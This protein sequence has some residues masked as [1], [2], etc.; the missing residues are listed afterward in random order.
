M[1]ILQVNIDGWLY[2]RPVYVSKLAEG[3]IQKGVDCKIIGASGSFEKDLEK[4]NVENLRIFHKWKPLD[5]SLHS[6]I[7]LYRII[8]NE[9]PDMVHSHGITE[10]IA[11]GIIAPLLNV[12]VVATYHTNPFD[13]YKN[14]KLLKIKVK[15]YF[16]ELF[17]LDILT[18]IL[19]R[20][21]AYV[22]VVSQEL[23][24]NFIKRG[25]RA[26]KI[27]VIYFGV[28]ARKNSTKFKPRRRAETSILF[29]G[30]VSVEKGCDCLLRACKRIADQGESFKLYLIGDGDIS[31]FSEMAVKLG[32]GN[33]VFFAGFKR[34]LNKFLVDSDIFVLPSRGEGLPISL[35]EAMS[36]GLPI[37]ATNVGGIPE[38]VEK[39]ENGFLMPV[40]DDIFLAN[41][42]SGLIDM[43]RKERHI[44]GL[45][46]K[47]K[48]KMLFSHRQ[49]VENYLDI[50][51]K[52]I[53][54]VNQLRKTGHL[55]TGN[56]D[57]QL[58]NN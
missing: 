24:K 51:K 58:F 29:V 37:I 11:M 14:E 8:K 28:D 46:N 56:H 18:K 39:G 4:N 52:A 30:R 49:M 43:G 2:G 35:L 36:C 27:K 40:G 22:T 31:F 15:R 16:Y 41:A 17:Y 19:F 55:K 50:Y 21:F 44:I 32:I 1:K 7:N 45:K 6:I 13:K 38:V 47:E 3:L 57:E 23:K 53:L 12:P 54:D 5:R 9:K 26:D 33:R 42:I 48:V 34:D 10:N 20:N 25:Y